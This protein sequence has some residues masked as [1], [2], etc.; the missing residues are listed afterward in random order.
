M[1]VIHC[2]KLYPVHAIR[3]NR[4][5]IL[6]LLFLVDVQGFKIY[7][8]YLAYEWNTMDHIQLTHTDRL[9]SLMKTVI[10]DRN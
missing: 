7:T 6:L 9:L 8:Y 2:N 5:I 10:I 1:H 4:T 3:R